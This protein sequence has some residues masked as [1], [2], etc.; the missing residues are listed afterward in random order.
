MGGGIRY[1]DWS[2]MP[3]GFSS[4]AERVLPRRPGFHRFNEDQEKKKK[5]DIKAKNCT[6]FALILTLKH[7]VKFDIKQ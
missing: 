4:K 3:K 5:G 2:T 6:G 7:L 1:D